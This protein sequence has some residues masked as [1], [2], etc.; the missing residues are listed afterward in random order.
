MRQQRG[1]SDAAASW[2]HLADIKMN[3]SHSVHSCTC[4]TAP[5]PLSHLF[6]HLSFLHKCHYSSLIYN[7]GHVY[8]GFFGIII[9]M[10]SQSLDRFFFR[11]P[12]E[13]LGEAAEVSFF[14][15]NNTYLHPAVCEISRDAHMHI[16][17]STDLG[18]TLAARRL[19][20]RNS[21]LQKFNRMWC[22]SNWLQ[23]SGW[24][25][26][27]S[28][29][30]EVPDNLVS[31]DQL[32][33]SS[34]QVVIYKCWCSPAPSRST[35]SPELDITGNCHSFTQRLDHWTVRG[36][37]TRN[38]PLHLQSPRTAPIGKVDQVQSAKLLTLRLWQTAGWMWTSPVTGKLITWVL[39]DYVYWCRCQQLMWGNQTC[40]N[41]TFQGRY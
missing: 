5:A 3:I 37:M 2:W 9:S 28:Q 40:P 26:L 27:H 36:M 17:S 22:C 31:S 29:L 38:T 33:K 30:S 19:P 12:E 1:Q 21:S 6:I 13:G 39:L 10:C 16:I 20:A 41:G 18:Y 32:S 14:I 11:A 23:L 35:I 4:S 15:E 34:I 25:M 24:C 8:E 7:E